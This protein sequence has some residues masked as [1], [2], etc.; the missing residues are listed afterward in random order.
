MAG[1]HYGEADSVL[2]GRKDGVSNRNYARRILALVGISMLAK[3]YI[4][5]LLRKYDASSGQVTRLTLNDP[6]LVWNNIPP[7]GV[8]KLFWTSCYEGKECA[9]LMLPLDYAVPDG[10]KA[11]V[12]LIKVPSKFSPGDEAYRG[13]I[14]LNPGGPGGSGVSLVEGRGLQFQQLIGDEFDIVGFDPRG[15]SRTTPPVVVFKDSAEDA[16]WR[17]RVQ[18]TPP[19]NTTVDAVARLWAGAQVFGSIA[20]Q[21]TAHS[22]PYVSTALVARD[23]LSISQAH[24]FDKLQYWGFS[25]GTVLGSTF[26][27]MFPDNVGRLIIDGVVDAENYYAGLWSNNLLDTDQTLRTIL[28]ACVAAGPSLCALYE[29]TT[30]EVHA[31]LSAIFAAL[32]TRPLPV[33]SNATGKEYA[34]IDYKTARRALFAQLYA[35]YGG[36]ARVSNYPSMELLHALAQLEKGDGLALARHAGLVPAS[37]PFT[38]ACPDAPPAPL[39]LTPDTSIAIGCGDTG[40][41]RVGDTPEDLEA[42]FANMSTF[43]EFADQWLFRVGCTGWT[44]Q[45][46]ERFSGAFVANTSYPLLIIGN[47]A[48]PVTP[49]AHARTMSRGFNNSVVLHQD[50][51]GHCSL[52]ATS[53][54]TAKAV[55]EYFREGKLPQPG[56]VCSVESTIFPSYSEAQS[57]QALRGE[58]RAVMKAWREIRESLEVPRFGMA[59]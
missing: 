25:Y 17:I 13:P 53:L 6:E 54:C 28:D 57:G 42:H 9:R 46:V 10:P 52:S 8:D 33:Y 51:A 20:N 12:A 19:P 18:D 11:G 22:S 1:K 30:D 58:D 39:L 45:S 4:G 59:F 38:C 5:P 27:A 36:T 40:L 3:V 16:A 29:N 49:L 2:E 43:T 44:T 32:K 34:L 7:S 47:T 55:R 56:T 21:S 14:L 50:S 37:T 31:R 26:A 35:P 48:D 23:M 24:G 41:A 15:I